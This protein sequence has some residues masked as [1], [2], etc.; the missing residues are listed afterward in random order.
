MSDASHILSQMLLL[1]DAPNHLDNIFITVEK[2]VYCTVF[3][4][5]YPVEA[6]HKGTTINP[7][8]SHTDIGTP[9]THLTKLHGTSSP[10][11]YLP[12]TLQ[13]EKTLM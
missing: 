12:L 6:F 3:W 7:Y 9:K 2:D 13:D 8:L 10:K 1:C 5:T 4:E 11:S